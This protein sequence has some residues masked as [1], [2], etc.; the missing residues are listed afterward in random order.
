MKNNF[1]KLLSGAALT[2]LLFSC[3]SLNE[4]PEFNSKDSFVSFDATDVSVNENAGTISIPVKIAS[5]N[6]VSTTVSYTVNPGT[7]V[8][9]TNYSL[10][11]PSAVLT[12]DGTQ[13]EASIEIN[14]IDKPGAFTGDLSF[15]VEISTASG[16]NIGAE[17]TCTVHILDLDHPLSDVLGDYTVSGYDFGNKGQLNWTA[18]F[19]KDASNTSIVWIKG[20]CPVLTT[21]ASEIENDIYGQ[22]SG[23]AGNRTIT[24]PFGQVVASSFNDDGAL[25]FVNFYYDNGYYGGTEGALILTP[26]ATGFVAKKG[27]GF[28]SDNYLY[29]GGVIGGEE[30][31]DYNTTF[32]KN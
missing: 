23:E 14:I 28:F 20:L 15:T 21:Y 22:V 1:V 17:N 7:A 12:F 29:K 6:P 4:K 27:F 32:T 9:G 2:L 10:A 16:L 18:T 13:R 24:I 11:D 5:I 31:G 25:T 3:S 8:S 26:T 19:Y 30:S